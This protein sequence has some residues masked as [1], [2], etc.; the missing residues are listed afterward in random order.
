MSVLFKISMVALVALLWAFIAIA[1]HIYR[2][3]QRHRSSRRSAE[4]KRPNDTL[5]S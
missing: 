4:A 3:R 5:G 1:R 2:D